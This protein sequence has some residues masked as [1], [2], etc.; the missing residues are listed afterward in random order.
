M[1][2]K[3]RLGQAYGVTGKDDAHSDSKPQDSGPRRPISPRSTA[4]PGAPARGGPAKAPAKSVG[5]KAVAASES[6]IKTGR[7]GIEKAAKFLLLLGRDEAANVIRHL[8][9]DEIEKVSREIARI[10]RID[11]VE[12]NEILTEFGWLAKTQGANLEGGPE[13]AE[14]MLAAA[15]GAEKAKEVIRK[16]VPES[17]KPFAF[18]NDFEARQLIVLFKD[19]SPQMIAM[20]LPY[21]GAKLA[22]GVISEL[23]KATRADVIQRIARLDRSSPDVIERVE[24]VLRDKAA[25][26]GRMDSGERIDGAAVLA[27]ILKHVDG[28]LEDSILSGIEEDNPTLSKDI[29]ERL[30]TADD[31][32]RVADRDM[33]KGLRDLSERDIA[34]V[35]KGKSQ[36]F[37]DK[38]LANVSQGKRTMVMEEYDIMGTVRRDEAEKATKSF[39]DFYKRKWE[40]GDLILEGDDDL[41]D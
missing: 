18:L 28:G 24:T 17:R 32:L 38:V 41:I 14:S 13:I 34:L 3:R 7:P 31:I 26:I 6:Y 33:Q 5:A 12:A 35:L 16:A 4:S 15:F 37:R 30:F 29:R 39:I 27:G 11:T 9:S 20:I 8:K 19:E 40:D 25:R 1:D 10:D 2:I 23:P 36:A 22:S 21:I